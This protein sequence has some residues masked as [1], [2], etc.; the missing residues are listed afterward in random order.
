MSYWCFTE[1]FV[2]HCCVNDA[3]LN[4]FCISDA[5]LSHWLFSAAL[6]HHWTFFVTMMHHWCV[7]NACVTEKSPNASPFFMKFGDTVMN[8]LL[9]VSP[10]VTEV[11]HI[12]SSI[13]K[14]DIILSILLTVLSST[15][16]CA[17]NRGPLNIIQGRGWYRIT[18]S[19]E[20]YFEQFIQN[21]LILTDLN[22]KI[23]FST[24]LDNQ[25]L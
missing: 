18:P 8:A 15:H 17:V 24:K 9:S 1:R 7:T 13:L 4:V 5:S 2:S 16:L 20:E 11:R 23:R 14:W 22:R 6:K 25:T 10:I 21:R 12:L 3:S 19:C